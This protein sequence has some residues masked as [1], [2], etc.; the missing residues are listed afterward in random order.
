MDKECYMFID[1]AVI[2]GPAMFE[3]L[4]PF[5][6]KGYIRRVYMLGYTDANVER[7]TIKLYDVP[8]VLAADIGAALDNADLDLQWM[9][10]EEE[11]T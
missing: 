2:D 7:V 4:R 8:F 3:V 9:H 10:H 1:F 11:P 6:E 5:Q